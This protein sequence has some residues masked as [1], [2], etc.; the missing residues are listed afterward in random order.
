MT[1]TRMIMKMT[2][3]CDE[4]YA[5]PGNASSDASVYAETHFVLFVLPN[6]AN[7]QEDYWNLP[8]LLVL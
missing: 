1:T 2:T 7:A 6:S 5:E 4:P 8:V 3:V